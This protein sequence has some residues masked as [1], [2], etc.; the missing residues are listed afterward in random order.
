VRSNR[1]SMNRQ[2]LRAWCDPLQEE[3]NSCQE[4]QRSR[5]GAPQKRLSSIVCSTAT[6][7]GPRQNLHEACITNTIHQLLTIKNENYNLTGIY[8]IPP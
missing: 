3:D 2:F 5:R 4:T 6:V 8:T 7:P 1:I